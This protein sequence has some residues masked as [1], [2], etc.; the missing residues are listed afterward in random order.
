MA[1]P[2]IS[3]TATVGAIYTKDYGTV[4][5]DW[6]ISNPDGYELKSV[7]IVRAAASGS[8]FATGKTVTLNA[9]LGF[10][11]ID[12]TGSWTD[13]GLALT[14][15]YAGSDND[16]TYTF[17]LTYVND[18]GAD[19]PHTPAAILVTIPRIDA[20]VSAPSED[21]CTDGCWDFGTKKAYAVFE[22][23]AALEDDEGT[24][25]KITNADGTSVIFET[26]D[27]LN[28][29]QSTSIGATADIVF[30]GVPSVDETITIISTDGTSKTYTA[31]AAAAFA[32]N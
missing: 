2:T 5:F 25:L 4:K 9:G 14:K 30:T 8:I 1:T 13:T 26:D 18:A 20:T 3:V 7:T 29:T 22:G 27:S 31:K 23:K 11:P 6:T 21:Y 16:T 15:D 28:E 24:T 10:N 17:T 19:A 12:T 32:S